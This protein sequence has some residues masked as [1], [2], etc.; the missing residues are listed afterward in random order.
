MLVDLFSKAKR[1]SSKNISCEVE[2][3]GTV[4]SRQ[5]SYVLATRHCSLGFLLY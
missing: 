3:Q 5:T 4:R 1:L 2:L